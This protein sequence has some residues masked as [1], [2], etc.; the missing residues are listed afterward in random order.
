MSSD[1]LNTAAASQLV[2]EETL[3]PVATDAEKRMEMAKRVLSKCQP[4]VWMAPEQLEIVFGG[5]TIRSFMADEV[6]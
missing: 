6:H 3:L 5:L 2:P 1:I 4:L